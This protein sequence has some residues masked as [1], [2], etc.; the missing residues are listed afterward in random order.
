RLNAV[1]A[2]ALGALIVVALPWWR[3]ADPLTGRQGLLSYAPS[4][5]AQALRHAAPGGRV[6][7]Q[8]T[9]AS[10]LEWAAP[11]ARYFV[12]SRFELFPGSVFTLYGVIAQGG[13][14]AVAQLEGLSVDAVIVAPDAPLVA[15]LDGAGWRRTYEDAT[16]ALFAR[17]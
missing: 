9:W 16:G 15:T 11:D 2:I 7:T 1:V 14:A 12:D 17:P 3:P 4:G 8:Q 5:L 10:W 6:F 13:D